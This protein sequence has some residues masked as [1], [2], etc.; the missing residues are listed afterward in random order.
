MK[1]LRRTA[2]AALLAVGAG[3]VV[4][5]ALA[6]SSGYRLYI[7]H[8]GSMVPTLRPGDIVVDRPVPGP[9]R[10]GEIITFRYH[11]GPDSVV[12]HRVFSAGRTGIRTKG[13][14]N[15]TPDPWVLRRSQVVGTPVAIVPAVGYVLFYLHEPSGAASVATLVLALWLLWNL[16]FGAREVAAEPA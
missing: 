14:A 9:V 13:D 3:V 8:T 10:R 5:A 6:V 2:V 1:L 12:T 4:L 7:V 16:C 11:S 15:P